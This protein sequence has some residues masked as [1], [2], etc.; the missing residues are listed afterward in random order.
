MTGTRRPPRRTMQRSAVRRALADAPGFVSAQDLHQR[1][2]EKGTHIGLAT[3]Y[4]QLAALVTAE[5]AD[6]ISTATGQ[7]YRACAS[8]THHHHLVC[9]SCGNAVDIE[10]PSEEW[11]QAAAKVHGY[12]ITRHVLEVFG[13]CAKCAPA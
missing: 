2:A 3:V 7:L 9:Q 4:R 6:T 1:L 13:L 8:G 5:E 10:P 12:T 11:I